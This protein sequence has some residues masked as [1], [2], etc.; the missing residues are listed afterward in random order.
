LLFLCASLSLA[1][2]TTVLRPQQFIDLG[3]QRERIRDRLKGRD[4]N[5]VEEGRY[6]SDRR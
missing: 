3:A 6:I 1:R 5:V 2:A 4:R